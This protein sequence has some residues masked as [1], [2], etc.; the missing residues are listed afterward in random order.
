MNKFILVITTLALFASASV[1]DA[2]K[3]EVPPKQVLFKNVNVLMG[4]Q[5]VSRS[6][7]YLLRTT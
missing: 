6:P 7:M 4:K 2:K 3:K 1:A 5:I